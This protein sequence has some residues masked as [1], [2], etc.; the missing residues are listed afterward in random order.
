MDSVH[1][2]NKKQQ[3]KWPGQAGGGVQTLRRWQGSNRFFLPVRHNPGNQSLIIH[4]FRQVEVE[5]E[6]EAEAE[7]GGGSLVAPRQTAAPAA[8]PPCWHCC[9]RSVSP[10][11]K[12]TLAQVIIYQSGQK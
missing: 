4:S 3:I 8:A 7:V 2:A 12:M 1:S 9:H 5:M 6:V 10:P 11:L